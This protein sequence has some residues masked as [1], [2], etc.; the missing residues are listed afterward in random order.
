[1]EQPLLRHL[2]AGQGVAVNQAGIDSNLIGEMNER[3]AVG[4]MS[5]HN[6][7]GKIVEVEKKLLANPKEIMGTL[8]FE[9][10]PGPYSGVHEKK[11]L[12]NIRH[13]KSHEKGD[14]VLWDA[15][16]DLAPTLAYPVAHERCLAPVIEKGVPEIP[17]IP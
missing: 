15:G 14:V 16:S 3:I 9:W 2:E 8:P 6:G 1:L 17:G 5:E 12:P 13:P 10:H 7:V 11:P 4:G